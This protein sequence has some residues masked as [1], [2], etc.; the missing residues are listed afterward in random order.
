MCRLCESQ[1][2]VC[3]NDGK[4][5][6]HLKESHAWTSG[7]KGGRPSRVSQE[8]SAALVTSFCKITSSPV[9]AKHFIE[10][11]SSGTSL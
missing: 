6:G 2:Y 10:A 1:P 7:D 11:I 4:M 3:R 5:K 9:V 8:A